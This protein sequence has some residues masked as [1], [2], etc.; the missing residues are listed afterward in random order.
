L[1]E[2]VP[3]DHRAGDAAAP[4]M[5]IE[6]LDLQC[7]NCRAVHDV[8]QEIKAGFGDDLLVVSRYFPLS[9]HEYAEE[10]AWAAEAAGRQGQFDAMVDLLFDQQAVWAAAA[11]EAALDLLIIGYGA[12]LGLDVDQFN[13]DRA[14]AA[15]RQRV[16]RDRSSAVA[17]GVS[18][19]PA[20]YLNGSPLVGAVDV[21]DFEAA[22]TAAL[23]N[24][25]EPLGVD[26]D[27]GS[28][29]VRDAAALAA[30][31]GDA[32]DAEVV[33]RDAAGGRAVVSQRIALT[34]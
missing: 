11:D 22:L 7:P 27:S 19:T 13:A 30:L 21:D 34:T 8:V 3:D 23:A 20:F 4:L 5:L 29:F 25:Q 10:A 18:S 15:V 12:Q 6:Y 32:L 2:L 1:L 33:V 24:L 16:A 9:V 26:R 28:L 14:D 17:L 31:S